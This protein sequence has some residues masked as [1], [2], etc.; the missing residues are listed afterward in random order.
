[1]SSS[2]SDSRRALP[3]SLV[4]LRIQL[5]VGGTIGNLATLGFLLTEGFYAE[6]IESALCAL[7]P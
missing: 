2:Q 4:A 5:Y 3:Q 6:T 1:M 7:W